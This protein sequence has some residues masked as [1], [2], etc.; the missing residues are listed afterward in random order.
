MS[1]AS[2][3]PPPRRA[4][5]WIWRPDA[6]RLEYLSAT[7]FADLVLARPQCGALVQ[8]CVE[9]GGAKGG[10]GLGG[11][12]GS[13]VAALNCT[14]SAVAVRRVVLV[15]EPGDSLGREIW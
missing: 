15:V 7:H 13:D 9:D 6:C 8:P 2:S 3:L 12:G 10:G 11:A 4:D 14:S 5:G 1:P